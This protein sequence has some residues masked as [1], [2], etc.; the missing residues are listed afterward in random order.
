LKFGHPP[1][2]PR[3]NPAL[4]RKAA[5]IA[6]FKLETE[7]GTGN[8]SNELIEAKSTLLAP[9]SV[10]DALTAYANAFAPQYIIGKKLRY[11]KGDWFAGDDNTEVPLGTAFTVNI[12]EF[13]A[14]WIK[15][16]A[17][18]G[19][20]HLMVR[21]CD[22]VAPKLRPQ[23][24]DLDVSKWE[25][26]KDGTPKDPWQFT[27]YLPMLDEKGELYT[28]TTNSRGGIGAVAKLVKMYAQ[29][30]KR[31]PDVFP[32]IKIGTD[33]YPH[34]DRT[35][36]RIKFPVFQPAGYVPKTDFLAALAEGGYATAEYPEAEA[37]ADFDDEMNDEVPF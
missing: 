32:L 13:M 4:L 29:H 15:W 8:M 6:P 10:S 3:S 36:G 7:E 30:R 2:R 12:D 11:S 16:L 28:F 20:E 31:H 9:V 5:L 27:N 23:L 35:L 22:G 18:K 1:N 34:K 25:L 17:S 14:G 19:V 37:V 21:V 26:Q 33:S 24:G